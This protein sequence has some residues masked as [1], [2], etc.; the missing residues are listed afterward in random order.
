MATINVV[1]IG[2]APRPDVTPELIQILGPSHRIIEHGALDLLDAA[3]IAALAPKPGETEFTSRLRDGGAAVFSHEASIPL[4]QQAIDRGEAAGAD[5]SLLICSGHFPVLAHDRPL[6]QLEKL[7]HTAMRG[8]LTGYHQPRL[9]VVRPLPSQLA[10][11]EQLWHEVAGA[12][13]VSAVAASPYTASVAEIA[14]AA[15]GLA[16]EVDVIVLDCIGY[17]AQ[18]RAAAQAASRE[19]GHQVEVTTVR[20]LGAHL[21]AALLS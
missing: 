20:A 7:A 18:T 19:L 1:T 15:A 17:G 14:Q 21:L 10:E 13:V 5:A 12:D 6:F 8:L 2:Q 16:G 9:G 11:A 3:G 4:V